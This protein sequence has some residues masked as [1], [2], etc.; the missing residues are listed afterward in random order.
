MFVG[1]V[2]RGNLYHFEL[3][4]ERTEL[5]LEG[6]LEDKVADDDEDLEGV[7]IGRNFGGIS[8]LEVGPD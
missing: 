1:D 6:P 7:I 8:D 5:L 3:N 2:H 4:E